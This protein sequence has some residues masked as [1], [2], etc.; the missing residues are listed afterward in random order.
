LFFTAGD[1]PA[2]NTLISNLS[3]ESS[4]VHWVLQLV[5]A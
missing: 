5:H 4:P 2:L 3:Q 1:P